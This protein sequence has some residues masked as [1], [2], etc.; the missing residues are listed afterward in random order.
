LEKSIPHFR[1]Y[2]NLFG[3]SVAKAQFRRY[4]NFVVI[5]GP[6]VQSTVFSTVRATL[7]Y[8]G[9]ESRIHRFDYVA[10]L[11][12]GSVMEVESTASTATAKLVLR[13]SNPHGDDHVF[14][15]AIS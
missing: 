13:K 2:A 8:L 10:T 11:S 15:I 5:F 7:R 9:C 1:L 12:G 3:A 14:S 4:G 6:R